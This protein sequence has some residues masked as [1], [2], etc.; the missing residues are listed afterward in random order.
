M[1]EGWSLQSDS[2]ALHCVTDAEIFGW[3]RPEPRRRRET[4]R[5]TEPQ[6]A[7]NRLHGLV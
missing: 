5:T 2:G 3:T 4:S 7:G 6:D 1:A